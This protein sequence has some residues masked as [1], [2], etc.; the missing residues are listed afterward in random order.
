MAPQSPEL[1]NPVATAEQH[2]HEQRALEVTRHPLVVEA[3]D[4]TRE[5][6]LSKAAPSPAMRSR[7]DACFEEV[8][9]SAAVWSLNQDPERPKVVTITRLAHEIGGLQVPG[10]RWGIDNP[11]SVYRVIPIS[12]DER[13]LIHGRVREERLAENYFTLWAENFNTVDVLS[14]A[15]LELE[16]DGH[17]TISVDSEAAGSRSNHIRSAPAAHEFYIRDVVQDWTR[18]TPNELTIERLGDAPS[19]PALSEDEQAALTARFMLHYA[20]STVRWNAQALDK[21]ANELAFTIDRDTDGA[22]RNQIYILGH[23]QLSDD[24]TLV[25]DVHTGGAGYFVAPITNVWGTTNEIIERTGSLNLSQSH[26]NSDGTYT[27]VVSRNDPGVH[28]WLDPSDMGEGILTLRWAEFP[29]G[30]PSAD[31]SAKS[32]VVPLDRLADAL[33]AETRYVTP[34]ERATQCAERAAGYRRRLRA[35]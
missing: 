2:E 5:H 16:A 30:M 13:Y 21:P 6:W 18:E 8:M 17:F 27:Y 25:L 24:E 28:N 29:S 14:G 4:R 7:F 22:L 10:S 15:D 32:R 31:V 34:S 12:G 1:V 23:F 11:D 9:F 20:D 26:A 19:R 35:D 33:P 3:F